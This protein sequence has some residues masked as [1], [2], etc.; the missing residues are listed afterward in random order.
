MKKL[1]VL[2]MVMAFLAV[3]V[4]AELTA[5]EVPES[6]RDLMPENPRDF[7]QALQEILRQLLPKLA[8]EF[9]RAMQTGAGL[10]AACML[11]AL[12]HPGEGAIGKAGDIVGAVAIAAMLLSGTGTMIRLGAQTITE[13]SEY[14]KLLLP[15]MTAAMAAQGGA[16]TATAL[17][18]A[19][20][21]F[22]TLL[23]RLLVTLLLP[24]QYLFLAAAT[25]GS[26][27]GS[28][29]LKG[30][31]NTMR[32]LLLWCLKTLLSLFSGFL[33]ITG[34]ISGS[35][36]AAAVKLTKTA[37]S[38][39]VPVV[40]SV[41]AEV[42]ETVLVGAGVVRSTIGVYGILAVLAVF[43]EPFCRIG[44]Q[45]L[46]LKLAAGLCAIFGTKAMTGLV[47]DFSEVMR[48]LL[49]MTGAMCILLL[50]STVCLL[51]GVS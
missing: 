28:D 25:A 50:V 45:Y 51:K 46:V 23:S 1:F 35:A 14:E 4:S 41:L 48:M 21:G 31:K 10:I 26:V 12:L 43:L 3:P 18:V 24:V 17:Y 6:G 22:N 29:T 20:A 11:V 13:M 39:V 42:S 49:G 33:G 38:T 2:W 40:G 27:L 5:P 34:V 36:D 7:G 15:V 37:V 30:L 8:P 16:G 44:I 47:G 9:T 32:D 19:A